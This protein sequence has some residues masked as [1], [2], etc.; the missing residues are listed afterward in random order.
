MTDERRKR[1]EAAIDPMNAGR[2]K[3]AYDL[4]WSE[5][6]FLD[7]ATDVITLCDELAAAKAEIERLKDALTPFAGPHFFGDNYVRFSPRL[8]EIARA[9]L[10]QVKP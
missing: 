4:T 6:V 3:I 7:N 2:Q 8:I 10:L 9:A 1:A 5:R